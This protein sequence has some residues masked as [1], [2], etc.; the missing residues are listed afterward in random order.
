M[1]NSSQINTLKGNE[2]NVSGNYFSTKED[3]ENYFS[4]VEQV[5]IVGVEPVA[6]SNGINAHNRVLFDDGHMMSTSRLFSAKGLRW[7]VGG[8]Q[9]KVEYLANAL[10]QGI[11]MTLHPESVDTRHIQNREG[12]YYFGKKADGK[13]DW[14]ELPKDETKHEEFLAKAIST[15]T[16]TFGEYTFP[17]LKDEE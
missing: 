4:N 17:N 7:P 8:N 1:Y 13:D 9:N 10:N 16:Y 11:E 12:K 5:R 3:N 6:A 2:K 15:A 14:R